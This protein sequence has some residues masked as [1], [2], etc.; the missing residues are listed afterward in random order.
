[1]HRAWFPFTLRWP[2][3]SSNFINKQLTY[4]L[5]QRIFQN[6]LNC[7]LWKGD[8]SATTK[9]IN[10]LP[11]TYGQELP[12]VS[13][14]GDHSDGLQHRECVIN[15]EIYSETTVIPWSFSPAP[16]WASLTIM[17]ASPTFER[18]AA[19]SRAKTSWASPG[20]SEECLTLSEGPPAAVHE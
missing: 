19:S 2:A 5:R 16:D 3:H 12:T 7:R 9:R 6:P 13:F 10:G 15:I 17:S 11:E 20:Q 1:M 4:E 18:A 8:L 14:T